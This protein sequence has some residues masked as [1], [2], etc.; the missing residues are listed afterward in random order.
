MDEEKTKGARDLFL[1]TLTKIGCQYEFGEEEDDD[2]IYFSYQ[3]EHFF[4]DAKNE[5]WYVNIHDMF[6]YDVEL[7]DINDFARL[8]KVINDSNQVNSV[9]TFYTIDEVGKKIDVHCR[10]II[11]FVSQI[12]NMEE[13]LRLELNE[14]FRP[15][16][17][18]INEM[19][20]LRE[21]EQTITS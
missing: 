15:H 20:K 13:Y 4:A 18:V 14:F 3:G 6:W 8:K 11:L 7:Y 21:K 2:Q 9:M 17:F 12:P 5:N 10:S 19:E 16:R 1:E